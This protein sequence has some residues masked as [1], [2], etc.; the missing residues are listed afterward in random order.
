MSS[1][2]LNCPFRRTTIELHLPASVTETIHMHAGLQQHFK[3]LLRVKFPAAS[4]NSD[5]AGGE[6]QVNYFSLHSGS[7]GL[8]KGFGIELSGWKT[9]TFNVLF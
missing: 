3:A 1:L 7:P 2:L 4:L 9:D 5:S 8:I 6:L